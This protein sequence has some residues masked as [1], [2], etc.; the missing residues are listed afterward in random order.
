[1]SL[2]LYLQLIDLYKQEGYEIDTGSYHWHFDKLYPL[3]YTFLHRRL[4]FPSLRQNGAPLSLGQ[5]IAFAELMLI[6]HCAQKQNAKNIFIIGNAFGWSTFALALACPQS[7]LVVIDNFQE[8]TQAEIGH[9]ISLRIKE[10]HKLEH[11][12]LVRAT[13]PEDVKGVAQKYFHNGKSDFVLIDGNHTNEQLLLDFEAIQNITTPQ[14]LVFL[15]DVINFDMTKAFVQ[16]RRRYTQLENKM[17]LRTPSG[18][19]CFF[20]T[21]IEEDTK[22]AINAFE[23]S[24]EHIKHTKQYVYKKVQAFEQKHNLSLRL[25][26]S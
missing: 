8:G 6:T 22:R 23:M 16:L 18:M 24:P 19:A 17:L 2:D 4:P 13:S 11:V 7:Q 20:T 1:M 21:G 3:E 15:H 12:H 25:K 10:K 5:G 9:R 26:K 14:H